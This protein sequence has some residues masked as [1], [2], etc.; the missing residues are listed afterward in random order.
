[1]EGIHYI[2]KQGNYKKSESNTYNIN[3]EFS[4]SPKAQV[5][6]F[7]DYSSQNISNVDNNNNKTFEEIEEIKNQIVE[8]KNELLEIEKK[9]TES[10]DKKDKSIF[11]KF[12]SSKSFKYIK[13]G[14]NLDF[15]LDKL[16]GYFGLS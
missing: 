15:S 7:S 12:F 8:F 1:M 2:E 16:A 4:N 10:I 11:Q 9:L 13:P 5:I 6:Q 3:N 14:L